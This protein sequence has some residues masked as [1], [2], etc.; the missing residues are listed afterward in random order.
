M[1]GVASWR[2]LV[3]RNPERREARPTEGHRAARYA[4]STAGHLFNRDAKGV[5]A[6]RLTICVILIG[7]PRRRAVMYED[8][9]RV[10]V[11]WRSRQRPAPS[12]RNSPLAGE[13]RCGCADAHGYVTPANFAGARL[14]ETCESQQQVHRGRIDSGG[15][16]S[17]GVD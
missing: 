5:A 8:D 6:N 16:T 15:N 10:I 11:A 13:V 3:G 1:L 12:V 2:T 14:N 7:N 17:L 4:E 9:L